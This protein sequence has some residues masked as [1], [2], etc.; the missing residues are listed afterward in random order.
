MGTKW[1]GF[2]ATDA[3][4]NSA[5]LPKCTTI[6]HV[7]TGGRESGSLRR[8]SGKPYRSWFGTVV[9]RNVPKGVCPEEPELDALGD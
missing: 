4:K 7:A 9:S 8:A 3:I 5:L 1:H 2:V 6:L